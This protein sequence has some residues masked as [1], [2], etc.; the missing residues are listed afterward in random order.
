MVGGGGGGGGGGKIG[1]GVLNIPP[2]HMNPWTQS[3]LFR[4]PYDNDSLLF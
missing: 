2:G 1:K 4:L 3:A